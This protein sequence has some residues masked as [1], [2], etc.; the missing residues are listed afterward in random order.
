M[1]SRFLMWGHQAHN[2][3]FYDCI[4]SFE[5]Y[6]YKSFDFCNNGKPSQGLERN[7]SGLGIRQNCLRLF[8]KIV[9]CQ[10]LKP[11]SRL[12]WE[13]INGLQRP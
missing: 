4:M 3:I 10:D 6:L 9:N 5:L 1:I 7:V 12:R 8:F 11:A 2:N 13:R